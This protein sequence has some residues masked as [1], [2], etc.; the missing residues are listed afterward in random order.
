MYQ[1][2][3]LWFKNIGDFGEDNRRI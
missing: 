3:L 1:G 2:R